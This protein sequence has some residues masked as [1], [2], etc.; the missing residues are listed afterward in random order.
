MPR[1]GLL[2]ACTGTSARC[3]RST[4]PFQPELSAKAP[5]TSTTVGVVPWVESDSVMRF[6][7][8][9]HRGEDSVAMDVVIW[10][11]Q[12]SLG[13]RH[14]H[15]LFDCFAWGRDGKRGSLCA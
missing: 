5:W 12:S 3:S 6:S 14:F 9:S 7:C 4:T 8:V 2:T 10:L 13:G 1:S 11:V 15:R